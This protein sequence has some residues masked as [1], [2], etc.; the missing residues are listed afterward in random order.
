MTKKPELYFNVDIEADGPL[1]GPN[2]M[3][4][5]GVVALDEHGKEHGSFE[6]N[7]HKLSD[8]RPNEE[9]MAWWSK[10]KN[11]EAY[12]RCRENTVP[13]ELA[14]A[15]F[16]EWVESFKSEWTVVMVAMPSGFDFLFMYW[17]MRL[18]AR[19]P[20]SFS[21][22]DM[23]TFVM[24]HRGTGYKQTSKRYWP[25][26]WFAEDMPHTHVA[27]DDAREQGHAFIAMLRENRE[28]REES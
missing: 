20:F 1:P 25:K 15:R 4:S 19:S 21:C 24:A 28:N 11:R 9:T 10:P 13:P 8:A 14:M 16:A 23:R 2:S 7:L 6:R 26:R 18:F 12:K 3:L 17:Y 22:V 27:I 5:F